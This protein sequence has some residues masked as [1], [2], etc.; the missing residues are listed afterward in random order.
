MQ[1]S[2][3]GL[4]V[5]SDDRPSKK[6]T[7]NSILCDA[8]QESDGM[9]STFVV[10]DSKLQSPVSKDGLSDTFSNLG[11]SHWQNKPHAL[12]GD[13]FTPVRHATDEN[14][15]PL[16]PEYTQNPPSTSSCHDEERSPRTGLMVQ[17]CLYMHILK[18]NCFI[19][20]LVICYK[21]ISVK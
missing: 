6:K 3:A 5:P 4:E 11:T 21:L 15:E 2:K 1:Y 18:E 8:E 16:R 19:P 12:D 7:A 13:S 20:C 17:L 10:N 14:N 9:Q